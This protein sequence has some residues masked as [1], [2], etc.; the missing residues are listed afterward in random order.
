MERGE[1]QFRQQRRPWRHYGTINWGHISL[2]L[3]LTDKFALQTECMT[4]GFDYDSKKYEDDFLG[5]VEYSLSGVANVYPLLAQYTLRAKDKI[6]FQL[7]AGPHLTS[8]LGLYDDEFINGKREHSSNYY[9]GK[10]EVEEHLG[11]KVPPVGFTVGTSF[12]FIRKRGS[13]IFL[14][15][16]FMG[17]MG[18]VKRETDRYLDSNGKEIVKFENWI[19]CSNLNFSLGYA[20]GIG[21]RV[22]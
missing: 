5:T 16:R 21:K 11:I 3:Q 17:D 4:T 2:R 14:D 6:S 15:I 13:I 1:I 12:G 18:A 22:P 8:N 20:W 9:F 7:F 10:K 19:Y